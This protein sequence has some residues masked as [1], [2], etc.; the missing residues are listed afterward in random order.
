MTRMHIT[1]SDVT[2][3]WTLV[4]MD[5][6]FQVGQKWWRQTFGSQK[7]YTVAKH[8]IQVLELELELELK[9]REKIDTLDCFSCKC[10]STTLCLFSIIS[11]KIKGKLL[12]TLSRLVWWE[13]PHSTVP[14]L[15]HC[16]MQLGNSQQHKAWHTRPTD[17]HEESKS[18]LWP[19][20]SITGATTEHTH[21]CLDKKPI[22][23]R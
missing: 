11:H 16:Y 19:L 2:N 1:C 23:R 8:T 22:V 14:W 3:P 7:Q 21:S 9:G 18:L 10:E 5:K 20:M 17:T 12:S 6:V 15:C 4:C 13:P